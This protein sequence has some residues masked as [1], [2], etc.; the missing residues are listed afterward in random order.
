[1]IHW[2]L[3]ALSMKSVELCD[4]HTIPVF[5]LTTILRFIDIAGELTF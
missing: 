4:S 2:A 1:M 3:R 5:I